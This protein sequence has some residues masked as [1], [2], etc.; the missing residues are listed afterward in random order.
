M[1]WEEL[2]AGHEKAPFTQQLLQDT[3]LIPNLHC[4]LHICKDPPP[5]QPGPAVPAARC[6]QRG[7]F[8]LPSLLPLPQEEKFSVSPRCCCP[9]AAPEPP[10]PSQRCP[11]GAGGAQRPRAEP[12]PPLRHPPRLRPAEQKEG[13]S[14][15]F[16]ATQRKTWQGHG[17]ARGEPRDTQGVPLPPPCSRGAARGP[18]RDRP[19]LAKCQ[20][21]SRAQLTAQ[22]PVPARLIPPALIQPGLLQAGN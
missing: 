22:R 10:L 12:V 4:L 3:A 8:A 7:L 15:H 14:S 17:G 13:A 5:G 20:P 19:A 2:T 11:V 9:G 6:G 16:L 21:R 1:G 18:A